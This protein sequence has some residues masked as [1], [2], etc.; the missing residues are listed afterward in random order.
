MVFLQRNIIRCCCDD[1]MWQQQAFRWSLRGTFTCNS[2]P[3]DQQWKVTR[4]E[5]H[6]EILL[7]IT[8]FQDNIFS[9]SLSRSISEVLLLLLMKTSFIQR[10]DVSIERNTPHSFHC[11]NG[12]KV[13]FI[14]LII[15]SWTFRRCSN[16]S[17]CV[18]AECDCVNGNI[19]RMKS[20]NLMKRSSHSLRECS[21]HQ[22][23]LEDDDFIH[24]ECLTIIWNFIEWGWLSQSCR[25]ANIRPLSSKTNSCSKCLRYNWNNSR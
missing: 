6:W 9:L 1:E 24:Y 23:R 22:W 8:L 13:P 5:S 19:S 7:P 11:G 18:L 14:Q 4:S 16:H 20:I 3:N 10:D 12:Q 2:Q 15:T 25:K 17:Q 21:S